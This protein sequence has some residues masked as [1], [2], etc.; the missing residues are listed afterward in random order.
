[1]PRPS[2]ASPVASIDPNAPPDGLIAYVGVENGQHVIRTVRPDGSAA[3]TIAE[4]EAPAWSPDG[5]LLA[6]QCPP[7]TAPNDPP[8]SDVC[9]AN[10]DGSGQR[11]I[12]TGAMSPSW[13]PDGASLL[14]A[15]SVIDAGDTWIVNLDGSSERRLGGGAGSWSPDGTWILLLGASGAEPDATIVHPDGNG[16]RQLGR[17]WGAA[18]SPDGTSLACTELQG[19]EGEMRAI[20]VADGT[21]RMTFSEHAQL[22]SP[23]WLSDRRMVMVMSGTGDPAVGAGDH[24]YLVDFVRHE[25]RM[26]LDGAATV[27]SVAPGGAWLAA[28]VGGTDI[29]LVSVDGEDRT[30]TT[31]GTSMGAEWQPRPATAEPLPSPS[32]A[33]PFSKLTFGSIRVGSEDVAWASTSTRLFRTTDSGA[34]WTEVR[35][36]APTLRPW[37]WLPM[38]T[39]CSSSRQGG[40]HGLGDA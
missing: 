18:W 22:A 4:G 31:D 9:V 30:L 29:H 21:L 33:P 35:P 32:A 7:A 6:F 5:M 34:T 24:L 36:P 25:S 28:D 40:R 8:A 26:L 1:M 16:A 23:T 14:F 11:V 37:A 19:T 17:C 12:V 13:S 39:P 10:A 15:R 38:R 20:A 3:R 2:D 27:T